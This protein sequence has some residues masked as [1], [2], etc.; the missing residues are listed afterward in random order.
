LSSYLNRKKRRKRKRR[1]KIRR[2]KNLP[3]LL[4]NNQPKIQL[5]HHQTRNNQL[6]QI[7]H[8]KRKIKGNQMLRKMVMVM[9]KTA[10]MKRKK[11]Q[12]KRKRRKEVSSIK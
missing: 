1:I 2:R 4:K 10:M 9:M 7:N 8:Q 11:I 6:S 3:V 5:I 12:Q